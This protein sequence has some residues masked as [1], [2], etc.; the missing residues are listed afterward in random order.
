MRAAE[1]AGIEGEEI[2]LGMGEEVTIGELAEEVIR[3]IGRPV[4]IEVDPARL[5]P[6][7][8]EVQRL[9]SDN[10][11]AG[12]LLGWA[13]EVPLKE[14]LARTIAWVREHLDRFAIGKY[15]V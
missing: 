10:R 8:S 4:R 13:P 5:R 11:K 15:Q 9:L 12:R 7:K 1:A 3:Q 2:N 6:E 14:G